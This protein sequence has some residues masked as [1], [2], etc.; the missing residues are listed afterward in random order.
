MS[1]PEQAHDLALCDLYREL[2][3]A[4]QQVEWKVS[5]LRNISRPKTVRFSSDDRRSLATILV[6]VQAMIDAGDEPTNY[7]GRPRPSNLLAECQEKS[8]VVAEVWNRIATH[9]RAY[10]G[11]QRFFL[12]T[13]SAGLVHKDMHCHTCNKGRKATTFALVASFSGT[14]VNQIVEAV[15]PLLCSVCFPQAPVEW[16]EQDRIPAR[17]AEVLFDRGYDEFKAEWDKFKAKRAK[18]LAK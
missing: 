6:D 17:V 18:R 2:A 11:W 8:N 16:Q 1:T 5:T 12:V 14:P 4:E 9:E 13:S 7:S 3:K 10:T 15:G